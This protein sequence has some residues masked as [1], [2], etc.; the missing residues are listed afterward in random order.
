MIDK[1]KKDILKE[2]IQK[3]D[4]GKKVKKRKVGIKRILFRRVLP[5]LFCS[6]ILLFSVSYCSLMLYW[7]KNPVPDTVIKYVQKLFLRYDLK[8]ETGKVNTVF[9]A[10]IR[11][12]AFSLAPLE[13][14]TFPEIAS[15]DLILSFSFGKLFRFCNFLYH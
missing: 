9:P 7:E 11:V 10:G 8:L 5:A 6:L 3:K 12:N 13:K 14:Y 15:D 2:D 1:Q 4:A